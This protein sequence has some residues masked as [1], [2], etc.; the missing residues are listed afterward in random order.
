MVRESRS[1]LLAAT[2]IDVRAIT[3]VTEFLVCLVLLLLLLRYCKW[4]DTLMRDGYNDTS[5]GEVHM[6]MRR[7]QM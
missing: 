5:S 6:I 3:G 2:R 4:F 1:F 7:K